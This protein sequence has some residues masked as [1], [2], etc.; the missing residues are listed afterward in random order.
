MK[1]YLSQ[2][3]F[4]TIEV[5]VLVFILSTTSSL[6][7]NIA[8]HFN[9][10]GVPNGFM[11]QKGYVIFMLVFVVGIPA[12]I[13]SG[14]SGALRSAQSSINIPNK[15]YWLAPE[16]KQDTLQ[17]LRSHISW[18][19]SFIA[20]FFAYI[21]WLLLKANSVQPVQ[22]PNDL[23]FLGMGVFLATIVIW[24]AVL[25]VRFMRVPKP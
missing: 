17:F 13:V 18:L 21:H 16:R 10:A 14:I 23:L 25:P 22:L 6:P 7:E 12:I 24:G 11:T 1:N 3:L 2:A 19:G 9:G 20:L 15:E 4:M 8:T 5:L